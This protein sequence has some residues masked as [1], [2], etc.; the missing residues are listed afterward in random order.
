MS[1]SGAG[2]GGAGE[3]QRKGG[4]R[5]RGSA[6]AGLPCSTNSAH[7]QARTPAD[8]SRAGGNGRVVDLET[9]IQLATMMDKSQLA[10][11]CSER[12]LQTPA[13]ATKNVLIR[14]LLSNAAHDSDVSSMGS[15]S[16]EVGFEVRR[17]S[18]V[19]CVSTTHVLR[20]ECAAGPEP[21]VPRGAGN[22]CVV[23]C[24]RLWP[25]K[26]QHYPDLENVSSWQGVQQDFQSPP[27]AL[28]ARFHHA[29][30]TGIHA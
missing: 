15:S 11:M 26:A 27:P 5:G 14:T 12:G 16:A 6:F 24:R 22:F 1:G 21:H 9:A 29:D 23:G 10:A 7:E 20:D 28:L 13:R 17:E 2:H 4:K 30:E 25:P 19:A 18:T 3:V 8:R